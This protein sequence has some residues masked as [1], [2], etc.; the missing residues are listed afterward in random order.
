MFYILLLTIS[1]F[2]MTLPNGLRLVL[3]EDHSSPVTTV[4]IFID[5]GSVYEEEQTGRGLSHFCEHV[6][7]SGTSKYHTEEEYA[8]MVQR[9][10]IMSN[11]YTSFERTCYHQTGP[12][13]YTEEMI[14]MVMEQVFTCQ[15]DSFEITREH[16]VITHEILMS[17][18][19]DSKSFWAMLSFI[20]GNHPVSVPILGF[21]EA[22]KGITRDI[23]YGFYRKHYTPPNAVMVIV[24]DFNSDSILNYIE[25]E[26]DKFPSEPYQPSYVNETPHYLYSRSDSFIGDVSEPQI[27]LI[28]NGTEDNTEA[29]LAL[30]LLSEYFSAGHSSILNRVLVMDTKE[31][32][33]TWSWCWS[34]RRFVGVFVLGASSDNPFKLERAKELLLAELDKVLEGEIE[35]ERFQRVKRMM[36]YEMLRDRTVGSRAEFIGQGMLITNDPY[37]YPDK[38]IEAINSLTEQKVIEYA[39]EYLDPS[40]VQI[41]YMIPEEMIDVETISET[42]IT[43]MIP[44]VKQEMPGYP[45][46]VYQKT[47]GSQYVSL[48][49]LIGGGRKLDPEGF[50]GVSNILAELIMRKITF[51]S[52]EE[53][54]IVM[55]DLGITK[56]IRVSSDFTY[57]NIGVPLE[58]LEKAIELFGKSLENID[59]SEEAIDDV[60]IEL[61]EELSFDNNN[62]DYLHS[63]FYYSKYFTKNTYDKFMTENSLNNITTHDLEDLFAVLMNQDNIVISISGDIDP[64]ILQESIERFFPSLESGENLALSTPYAELPLIVS[65]ESDS[66]I[67]DFPQTFVSLIYPTG[68]KYGDPEIAPM[69]I[70]EQLM[71]GSAFRLH[72]ALRGDE[73]LVY[74]GWGYQLNFGLTGVFLFISQTSLVNEDRIK[75]IYLEQVERLK[76]ED[77]PFDELEN[78]KTSIFSRW[79]MYSQDP[80]TRVQQAA[81]LYLFNLPLDY[82]DIQLKNQIRGLTSEDVRAAAQRY[83]DEG[84]WYISRPEDVIEE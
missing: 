15:F 71:T 78:A 79:D 20:M 26:I 31:A 8:E 63:I 65:P 73:D 38:Y 64:A 47:P 76:N 45:T 54:S 23:V 21:K 49:L 74:W 9:F 30:T 53:M 43:G 37:Y 44:F 14:S 58:N 62:P 7:S 61:L 5:V 25:K 40:E 22:M 33:S 17:E 42:E 55:D 51:M 19:P 13:I 10:G 77:I 80:S 50:E 83:L 27:N 16:G 66:Q 81:R 4:R 6:V 82:Y 67:Y 69:F 75:E 1:M 41:Y 57:I 24:G 18:T 48:T 11:A 29:D 70:I 39:R 59:F 2:Q 84:Y 28:W 46:L 56:N 52:D 3:D 35:H 60:R 36:K 34:F 72:R 68:L 32:V 12:S